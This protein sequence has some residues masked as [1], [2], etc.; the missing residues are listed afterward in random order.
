MEMTMEEFQ[1]QLEVQGLSYQEHLEDFRAQLAIQDYLYD[2]VEVPEVTEEDVKEFY[3]AWKQMLPEEQEPPH[4]EELKSEIIMH[5]EQQ[6]QQEAIV[7]FIEELRA[8]A[9]IEYM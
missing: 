2:A 6:K 7:P 8:K 4:F 9:D 1:E 5:L 3:E